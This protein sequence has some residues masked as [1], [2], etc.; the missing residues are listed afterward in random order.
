MIGRAKIFDFFTHVSN[1]LEFDTELVKKI[2]TEPWIKEAE[3]LALNETS[4]HFADHSLIPSA[5]YIDEM[6]DSFL[7]I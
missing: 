5:L 4:G 1:L 6:K 7:I 3:S 2:I